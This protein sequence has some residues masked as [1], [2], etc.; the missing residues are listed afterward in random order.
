MAGRQAWRKTWWQIHKWIGLA[1]M[2]LLIPLGLSGIVLTW[3]DAIDHALNSQR[4]AVHGEATLAPSVYAAEARKALQPGDRLSQIRYPKEEGP[5]V[6]MATG[7]A[8]GGRHGPPLRIWLWLDPRSA[9]VIEVSRGDRGLVRI[10]HNFHGMLFIPGGPGRALVGVL[11]V[12][13]FLMAFG[14]VWL[15]WP[16]IGSWM[17]GLRWQRGD[18]RLDTNL[19]HRVGFWIALPLAAQAFTGVWM[20]W[21]QMMA[22]IG[23]A[24]ARGGMAAPAGDSALTVDQALAAAQTAAPHPAPQPRSPLSIAWP[25]GPD[26]AWRISLAGKGGDVEVNDATRAVTQGAPRGGGGL[27]GAMRHYH[28]GTLLG[29]IWRVLLVLLGLSPSILGITGILMWLRGRRWR[30]KAAMRKNKVRELVA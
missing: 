14:G 12:A 20:A 2:I 19:H 9:H 10:A 5:V 25:A 28:D 15:W 8:A 3:D 1:L 13:M 17:T 4:Y 26:G 21:P 29:P 6:V 11:G 18:R 16:P 23:L 30:A 24:P 7:A 22:T 27:A